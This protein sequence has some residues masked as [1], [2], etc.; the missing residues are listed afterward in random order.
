MNKVIKTCTSADCPERSGGECT[1]GAKPIEINTFEEDRCPHCHGE[2]Y[3][4][5]ALAVRL[6]KEIVQCFLCGGWI[7]PEEEE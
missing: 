3:Y 7:K 5:A 4:R 2:M 1:A 6:D